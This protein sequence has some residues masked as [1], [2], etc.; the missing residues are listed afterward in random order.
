MRAMKSAFQEMVE[1]GPADGQL[2][3]RLVQRMSNMWLEFQMHRCR[4]VI[5]MKESKPEPA[6]KKAQV[7]QGVLELVVVPSVGRYGNVK[8]VELD[9]FTVIGGCA[10]DII[11]LSTT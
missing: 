9:K 3:E 7:L 2:V 4:I 1:F 8:G 5:S 10:G 11:R 6:V